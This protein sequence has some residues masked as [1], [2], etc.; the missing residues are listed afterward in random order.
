MHLARLVSFGQK[1]RKQNAKTANPPPAP[2]KDPPAEQ[3]KQAP[4]QANE[5]I[6]YIVER[7]KRTKSTFSEPKRINFK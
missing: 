5:P 4:S 7:K 6:Y 3:K 2:P 1:Y